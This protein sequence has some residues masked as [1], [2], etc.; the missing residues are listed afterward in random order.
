M[1]EGYEIDEPL[2]F[3]VT[4]DY[5][6]INNKKYWRVT[7]VKSIINKEGLNI[8]RAMV[9]NKNANKILHTRA[10]IGTKMHQVF[11]MILKEFEIKE[12]NYPEEVQE[13]IGLFYKFISNCNILP[14]NIEQRLWSDELGVAG[15]ADYIGNYRTYEKYLKRGRE[16]KFENDSHVIGDWKSSSAIH[17]DYW[18]QLATYVYMFEQQTG[19]SLDGA[20]IAQFRDGKIKVE[21]KTREEL[22][23][24][25]EI[26]RHCIPVFEFS[27]NRKL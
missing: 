12:K 20:F 8:W 19:K 18:L 3:E 4:D 1:I 7:R 25:L 15:T 17:G 10:G 27:M 22:D 23:E 5:Y 11:E 24:Y 26:M 2:R 14:S 6:L 21:E 13:D 16:P 9:G